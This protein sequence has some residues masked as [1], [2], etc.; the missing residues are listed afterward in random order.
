MEKCHQSFSQYIFDYFVAMAITKKMQ[1][2][3]NFYETDYSDISFLKLP[4]TDS[5]LTGVGVRFYAGNSS[6]KVFK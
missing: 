5:K 2:K 1:C 3:E 6:G 4:K